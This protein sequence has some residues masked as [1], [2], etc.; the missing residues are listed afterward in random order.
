MTPP[1][2]IDAGGRPLPL[3]ARIGGGGEGD[4]YA[5]PGDAQVVKLYHTPPGAEAVAKLTAMAG[6][7]TAP[8]LKVAAW[9]TGLVRD[10]RTRQVA[11]FAM[12]RVADCQPV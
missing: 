6:L 5:L 12:P 7:G 1:P 9:P 8:L 11:G 2:V 10:A 4:V 3:G